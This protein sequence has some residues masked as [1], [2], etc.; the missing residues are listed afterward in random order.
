MLNP[1]FIGSI[2]N[3][4]NRYIR[5][6]EKGR[7]PKP[8]HCPDCR[9]TGTI[10]WSGYERQLR[11]LADIY[12]LPIK[13]V[14]CKHCG[15]TFA[16]LPEFIKKFCRYGKDVI[17]YVLTAVIKKTYE[18]ISEELCLDNDLNISPLT[19]WSWK[20]KYPLATL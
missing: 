3:K 18:K 6:Y 17:K 14:R 16:V 11:N 9:R 8:E 4:I 19:I 15:K 7:I 20:I 1:Q 5:Y 10:W 13:R 12:D 2:Q